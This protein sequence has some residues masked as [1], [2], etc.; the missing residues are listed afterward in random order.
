MLKALIITLPKPGKDPSTPQNFRP[1]W[2]L[3]N[4]LKLYAKLIALWLVDILPEIIHPDQ[5]GFSK[6]RQTSDATRRLLNIIHQA[7]SCRSP[8][9]LLALDAEKAFDHVHWGYLTEVLS[10]FGFKGP[11]LSAILA[12]YTSPSA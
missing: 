12:L 10:A 5:S 3:N 1:L 6:G 7:K 4:D 9:L 2:L 11:I 8:S